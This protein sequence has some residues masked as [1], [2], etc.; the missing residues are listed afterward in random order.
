MK[1]QIITKKC[2]YNLLSIMCNVYLKVIR[3]SN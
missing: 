2:V 3:N 1:Q